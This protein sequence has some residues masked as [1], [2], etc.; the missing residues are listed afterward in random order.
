VKRILLRSIPDPRAPLSSDPGY[1]AGR[2]DWRSMVEQ[3]VR[4]PLDREKGA[5][6]DEMRKSI[7]ILDALDAAQDDVLTL[8]DA[9]WEFLKTKVEKCPWG[10]VDRRILAFCDDVLEATD[11]PRDLTRVDGV[12]SA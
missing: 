12:A 4:I 9:D 5:N 10:I 6:I 8:E 1:E 7:R 11:S 3:A 2:A